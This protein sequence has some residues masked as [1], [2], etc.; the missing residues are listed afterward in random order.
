[1]EIYSRDATE[2]ARRMARLLKGGNGLWEER[3]VGIIGIYGGTVKARRRHKQFKL[4]FY[5]RFLRPL[6]LWA[7]LIIVSALST[8]N[9]DGIIQS[10]GCP[11]IQTTH[12]L[13]PRSEDRSIRS[14]EQGI[15][16]LPRLRKI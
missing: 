12:L 1:M 4:F 14:R 11:A 16:L 5:D 8:Q 7:D 9:P 3:T 13:H 2:E 6:Y 10:M 15:H